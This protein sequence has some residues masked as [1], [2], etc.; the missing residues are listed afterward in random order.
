MARADLGSD[1]MNEMHF[2]FLKSRRMIVEQAIVSPPRFRVGS[3]LWPHG[4]LVSRMVPSTTRVVMGRPLARACRC[5]HL[6]GMNCLLGGLPP[7][8]TGRI[9]LYLRTDDPLLHGRRPP[10][11]AYLLLIEAPEYCNDSPATFDSKATRAILF[12]CIAHSA[13]RLSLKGYG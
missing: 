1:G 9:A 13:L 6:Q 8:G 4:C 11:H 10:T 5:A 3:A 2:V 12:T 7:S